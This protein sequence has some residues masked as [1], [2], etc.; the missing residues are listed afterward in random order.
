MLARKSEGRNGRADR[1]TDEPTHTNDSAGPR[2]IA[3][4]KKKTHVPDADA[5]RIAND[6]FWL[7]KKCWD[8]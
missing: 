3:A 2:D 6:G 7:L 5:A 4:W 1:R 8:I